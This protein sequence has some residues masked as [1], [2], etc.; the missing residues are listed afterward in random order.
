M[1][2]GSNPHDSGTD[3]VNLNRNAAQRVRAA[4]LYYE[5]QPRNKLGEGKG[6][7]GGWYHHW[8]AKTGAGGI[9]A[10]SAA[11]TPGQ[12]TVTLCDWNGTKWVARTS[13]VAGID[14]VTALN[15][16]TSA[17]VAA[18]T[19]VTLAWVAGQWEVVMEP[20]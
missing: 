16:A 11:D 4:T 20:C 14:T 1:M 12:A 8:K 3:P 15:P 19:F 18:N 7:R 5:R 6:P 10:A 2:T 13:P 17:A 9:A